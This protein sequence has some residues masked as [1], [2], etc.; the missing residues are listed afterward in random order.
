VEF[1]HGIC[2]VGKQVAVSDKREKI[3]QQEVMGLD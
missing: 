2:S 3:I 1:I